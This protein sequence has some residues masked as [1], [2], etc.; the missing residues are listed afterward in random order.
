M[1]NL[2]AQK[3][4]LRWQAIAFSG[5]L[6]KLILTVLI[7][8]KAVNDCRKFEGRSL[9]QIKTFSLRLFQS[10]QFQFSLDSFV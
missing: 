7:F 8:A 5:G 2:S 10:F 9:N 3:L 6:L 4:L 1:L